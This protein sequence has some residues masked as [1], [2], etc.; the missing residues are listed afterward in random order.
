MPPVVASSLATPPIPVP[1]SAPEA[2]AHLA[3][4][5]A[6][7]PLGPDYA[8]FDA[9]HIGVFFH[10][11]PYSMAGRGEWVMNR[12]LIPTADYDSRHFHPWRA[13]RFDADAWM[14][15]ALALGATYIVFTT[16]HHDG[17]ALWKSAVN[18]RNTFAAGPRRDFVAEVAAAARRAGLRVGFYYS[19]AN[20]AHADYPTPF[21]RDWPHDDAWRD[22]TQRRRFQAYVMGELRE[23]LDGRYGRVDYLWYD[24]GLPLNV[25][26][27]AWNE[28]A[29]E[30]QPGILVNNRGGPNHDIHICERAIHATPPKGRWEACFTLNRNWGYHA[31]DTSYRSPRELL[32]LLV[33][34]TGTRGKLLINLGPRGDG[35]V[36]EESADVLSR[37]GVW[38]KRHGACLSGADTRV[39][40]WNNTTLAARRG[41]RVH[42]YILEGVPAEL[43][44]CET[45]SPLVRAFDQASG[46]EIP[47]RQDGARIQLLDTKGLVTPDILPVVTLEFLAEPQ[48][49]IPQTTFWIPG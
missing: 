49:L 34:T 31:H 43:W 42:L 22:E 33:N 39:F 44:W 32:E 29:R 12:E 20:W 3:A 1:V 13:E 11:G 16:R 15:H 30:L 48:P 26:D 37:C 21:A 45:L 40:G 5:H 25:C 36:P 46:R 2:P 24:G 8:W 27:P 47:F 38:I 7:P 17:V 6:P 18:P 14:R 41:R 35:T 28:L 9:S 19:I 10:W 23:L 4:P